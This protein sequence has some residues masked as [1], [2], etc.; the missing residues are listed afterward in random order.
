MWRAIFTPSIGMPGWR[1]GH[2]HDDRQTAFCGVERFPFRH[3]LGALVVAD[4]FFQPSIGEFIRKLRAID[5]DGCD[6]AGVDQL[7][8]TSPLR[9]VQKIFRSAD[10]R[11]V[12]VLLALGPQAVIGGRMKD[13][14][15]A[16]HRA[17]KRG[18]VA[19]IT[20]HIFERQIRDR[21]IG[22]GRAQQHAHFIAAGHQLPRHVAAKKSRRSRDQRGHATFTP[23]SVACDSCSTGTLDFSSALWVARPSRLTIGSIKRERS[24]HHALPISFRAS[25]VLCNEAAGSG[26]AE[27]D[28]PRASESTQPSTSRECAKSNNFAASLIPI[29]EVTRTWA[30]IKKPESLAARMPSTANGGGPASRRTGSRRTARKSRGTG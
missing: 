11:I 25:L 29:S 30:Q 10:V 21:A 7:L 24:S 27:L 12:N 18:G 20:G 28:S 9:G 8:D 22:A 4:H 6:R 2:C 14:L 1:R 23:S 16:L 26:F 13:A 15:D 19:Q 3:P 17:I 5:G